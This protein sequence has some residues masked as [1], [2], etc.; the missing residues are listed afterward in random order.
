MSTLYLSA[1]VGINMAWCDRLVRQPLQ[2]CAW[3]AAW[4]S[5]Q[6]ACM[7]AQELRLVRSLLRPDCQGASVARL[8]RE[9][10]PLVD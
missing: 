2:T 8:S 5:M 1:L 4:W 10:L 9:I 6:N 7:A 3:M